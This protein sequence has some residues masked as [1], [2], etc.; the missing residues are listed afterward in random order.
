MKGPIDWFKCTQC[1]ELYERSEFAVEGKTI[2]I[3]CDYGDLAEDQ[4]TDDGD[5]IG[6]EEEKD[7]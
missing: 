3:C 7:E 1:G 5:T 2:C 6:D 4:D